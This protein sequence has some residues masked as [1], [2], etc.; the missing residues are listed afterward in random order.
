MLITKISDTQFC[1][2]YSYFQAPSPKKYCASTHFQK[3]ITQK[4]FLFVLFFIFFMFITSNIYFKI[5]MKEKRSRRRDDGYYDRDREVPEDESCFRKK[6]NDF[7]A[8]PSKS[9]DSKRTLKR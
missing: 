7:N 2:A 4:Q 1:L 9:N 6:E 8:T 5:E 3:N